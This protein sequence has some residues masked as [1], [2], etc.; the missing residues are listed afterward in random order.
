MTKRLFIAC[1]AAFAAAALSFSSATPVSDAEASNIPAAQIALAYVAAHR[2]E[3]GLTQADLADVVVTDAYTSDHTGVSHVY[4]RQRFQ[5]I[6]VYNGNINVNVAANGTVLSHGSD[7]VPNLTSAVNRTSP[8]ITST[9]AALAAAAS[10]ELTPTA[11][12]NI[13]ELRAG[14]ARE[15]VLSGGG[16]SLSPIPVKLVYQ[17]VE[18]TVRLAWNVE[19]EEVSQRHWWSL[20]VDAETGALLSKDDFIDRD[21]SSYRVFSHPL[22]SP[23]HGLRSLI[24]SPAD[25]LASPFGWHDTNGAAG[26]EF[27]IT[28]GNNAHAYADTIGDGLPD[29]LSEPDG[30]AALDF[31]FPFDP[32]REPLEYRPAAVTNLFYWNNIIHDVFYRYGFTE[33]AGNFQVNNYGRGGLGNDYVQAEAQDGTPNGASAPLNNANFGTPVDGSRPRM[34]MYLW[35]PPYPNSVIVQ[36][37][38]PIAGSYDA[39]DAQFGA[40]VP[41]VGLTGAVV[42]VNDGVGVAADACE[43]LIG[44]PAGSIALLERGTCSFTIK[45]LNAQNAGATA[46]ILHNNVPGGPALR[47]GFATTPT[48][49]ANAARV[50]IPSVMVSYND[51]HRFRAN[52]PLTATVARKLEGD[53]LRDGDFDSGVITHEY[54]HGISNRLTGGPSTVSCLNNQEQMGEGWSDFLGLALT[55]R[56]GDTATQR[57]GV[58]TYV[59]YQSTDGFGIR[60]TPYSTDM[61]ANPATYDAIKTA[62]V[63]HGVG[64]IWASML[65][66]VYWNLVHAHGYNPDVYGDWTTGGNN[67]AIQLV[68]DGMKL[69]KCSP[70]FVDGRDAILQANQILTGGANQCSIWKAFAKRGLGV[71]AIQGSSGSVIDGTQAFDVPAGCQAGINVDPPGL[72]ATQFANTTTTQ[73]LRIQNGSLGGGTDL[74]WSITEAGSDCG[75]PSDLGWVNVSTA[76]G[77]TAPGGMSSVTVTFNSAGLSAPNSLTG[78][79]CVASNDPTRPVVSVPLTLAGIYNFQGFFGSVKNPPTLNKINSGSTVSFVFGLSGNQGL[80]I[81]LTDSPSSVEIDCNTAEPVGAPEPALPG[82]GGNGLSYSAATNRYTYRWRTQGDW[83]VGSCRE[84]TMRL[85]DG[86]IHR[87]LFRFK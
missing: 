32:S 66:E 67:L 68:I 55:A 43:P 31:D 40:P 87:A 12:L 60:P 59:L 83:A 14:A 75:T 6:E 50:V 85:N 82:G 10:V 46:A 77:T 15:V 52:L 70:G 79:L 21:G 42:P 11:L 17:P 57:R 29:P 34:Q 23:N 49:D 84:F 19:I 28:R 16:I 76:S 58:G 22:E 8:V 53:R 7:F 63:P 24:S 78:K 62:A 69:Q 86:T 44:F 3:L 2:E 25:F 74:V 64:Y 35:Q 54:G 48:P 38:S 1:I 4:L 65:W 47:I 81:F 72:T 36:A 30:G 18:G 37:P 71:S 80:N 56:S 51:G 39:T 33:A 26:P 13:L 20:R 41:P 5:G 61:S 73:G 27:T 45:V 9:A